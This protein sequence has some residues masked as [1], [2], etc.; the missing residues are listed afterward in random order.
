[1]HQV[2]NTKGRALAAVFAAFAVALTFSHVRVNAHGGEDHSEKKAPTVST[3]TNMIVRA[4][5]VGDLEVTIKHPPL[6]P[7]KELAARVFVTRYGTNEPIAGAKVVVVFAAAG[8]MPVEV[9]AVASNTLGI[10]EVK[11]SPMP[12]GDYTLMARVEVGGAA[13]AV[14]FGA[15]KVAPLPPPAAA[16]ESSWA[17]IALLALGMLVGIGLLGLVL[18]RAAMPARRDRIKGEAATA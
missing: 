5:H 18:Y 10:H 4:E 12:R 16:D 1:M 15:I 17:R 6:E 7:D 9:A 14:E 3:G 11:F 13:Q 8:G 2:L